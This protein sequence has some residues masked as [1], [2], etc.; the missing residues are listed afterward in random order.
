MKVLK[1]ITK[2]I[3][4]RVG[5]YIFFALSAAAITFFYSSDWAYGVISAGKRFYYTSFHFSRHLCGNIVNY[6]AYPRICRK[7]S[8]WKIS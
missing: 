5:A 4:S 7:E 2:S 1:R 3:S 8:E 6:A